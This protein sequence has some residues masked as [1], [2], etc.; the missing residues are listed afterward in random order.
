MLFCPP[1]GVEKDR[2]LMSDLVVEIF[3]ELRGHFFS[4]DGDPRPLEIRDKRN[5]Q[6]DP[7]DEYLFELLSRKLLNSRCLKAPGPLITP[8]FVIMR[9]NLS[10]ETLENK[11]LSDSSRIVGIEVKKLERTR[12]GKVA[13]SSGLDYNTTPPCGTVRVYDQFR[14]PVDIR[15]FYLFVCLEVGSDEDRQFVSAIALCDG[16]ALNR[17]FDFY[18]SIIGQRNKQINLGT[19]G[20]GA[21]RTRPMLIFSNPLG[22]PAL[23]L[24][25]TLIHSNCNLEERDSRIRLTHLLRRTRQAEGTDDF[26][27]Y[28]MKTDVSESF[29]LTKLVDPFPVP[30]RTVRTQQRGRFIIPALGS[31]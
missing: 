19:Y 29:R 30:T 20:D 17:D 11:Q 28:R 21:N 7:F 15:G 5:T 23:D 14:Q 24:S 25:V 13:R 4:K 16:N 2:L 10:V 18:L 31:E 3:A 12:T 22:I 26:F 9:P 1:I 27:C 8:D 6:D